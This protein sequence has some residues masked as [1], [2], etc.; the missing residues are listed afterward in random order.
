M[1]VHGEIV[2]S[3]FEIRGLLGHG[4]CG[5]VYD[6]FD[7]RTS[8][9]VA[10]KVLADDVVDPSAMARLLREARVAQAINHPNVCPIVAS[11][12]LDDGRHFMAT[13][14]LIGQ[15]LRDYL[16]K[17]GA[18]SAE[19]TIEIGVQILSGL[20]AAHAVGVVHRDVKPENV[21][22]TGPTSLRLQPDSGTARIRLLDFG[23][24]RRGGH[25]L[26][27]KTLTV[28]GWI[29]GT[30]GYLAPEQV[31]GDRTIDPSVDLF[32][33]GVVLF[34]ALTGHRALGEGTPLELITHLLAKPIPSVRSYR[35][36]LPLTLDRIVAH[37]TER[38]GN[39]RYK[40]AAHFQH[41]LLEARTAFRREGSRSS[42]ARE[43]AA[44]SRIAYDEEW[45]EPTRRRSDFRNLVPRRAS[46]AVLQNGPMTVI[47]GNRRSAR[48]G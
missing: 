43:A 29:V 40:T 37:A 21:F 3:R 6:A 33:V 39:S 22:V 38:D 32:A 20:D 30:P 15:T 46:P 27:E 13:E 48:H 42:A 11:G 19:E 34:E 2:D 45:N 31:R 41:E 14:L 12:V 5:V 4:G 17:H 26:D 9:P 16:T 35:P 10:L 24:C 1:A 8:R 7:R 23:L 25:D 44:R 36:E 47:H 18:L 28:A